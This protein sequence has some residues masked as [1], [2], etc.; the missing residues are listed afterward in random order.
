M[1][2]YKISR[3]YDYC[4]TKED[5][6]KY[7]L[8]SRAIKCKY[9]IHTGMGVSIISLIFI[10][11][12]TCLSSKWY[13]LESIIVINWIWFMYMMR[14][15][16]ISLYQTFRIK[17]LNKKKNKTLLNMVM[18]HINEYDN[19]LVFNTKYHYKTKKYP[20]NWL[21]TKITFR[22]SQGT[23][24]HYM[25]T[26]KKVSFTIRYC[27]KNRTNITSVKSDYLVDLTDVITIKQFQNRIREHFLFQMKEVLKNA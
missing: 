3:F 19:H 6:K 17:R 7:K 14:I 21:K 16:L 15:D 11:I 26:N 9:R 1:E 8:S 10:L 2:Q 13:I 22:D 27:K 12:S 25:I 20:F 23:L 24:Y 4:T 18:I 5:A